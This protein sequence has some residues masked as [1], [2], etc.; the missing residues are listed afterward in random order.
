VKTYAFVDASNIIYGAREEGWLIDQKKLLE[1]LKRKYKATNEKQT[2]FLK[3]LESFGYTL[4]VKEIKRYGK[5]TKANCDV[6][7]TMDMLLLKDKYDTGVVLS[8]DGDFLPL[9]EYLKFKAKKKISI[10]A[11]SRRTSKD[12]KKFAKQEFIGLENEKYILERKPKK[13]GRTLN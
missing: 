3:K 5:K 1:Y 9:F 10:I 11:F 2:K 12:L 6:D 13:M 7:L 4:R 8:G